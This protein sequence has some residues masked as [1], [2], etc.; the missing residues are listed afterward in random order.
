[1]EWWGD[2]LVLALPS[3]G[4]PKD[5]TELDVLA[6]AA[7]L[8]VIA[9]ITEEQAALALRAVFSL[10]ELR[11]RDCTLTQV[12]RCPRHALGWIADPNWGNCTVRGCPSIGQLVHGLCPLHLAVLPE[13]IANAHLEVVA[14]QLA[15]RRT[16]LGAP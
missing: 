6:N 11:C 10:P 5:M 2:A 8:G 16:C 9:G 7:R 1:M 13:L 3:N 14:A 12:G 4:A 15:Q